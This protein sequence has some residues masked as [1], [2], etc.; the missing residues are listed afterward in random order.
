MNPI[1][2]ANKLKTLRTLKGLSPEQVAQKAELNLDDYMAL[3]A[4]KNA[5][6]EDKLAKA[7]DALGVDIEEWFETDNS[8]VFIN[9]GEVSITENSQQQLNCE[10]CYFYNRN[11]EDIEMMNA[12]TAALK[13]M[14]DKLS[15]EVLSR[16]VEKVLR[17]EIKKKGRGA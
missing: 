3:E 9:S 11:E 12:M 14:A 8:N 16:H 4:G 2:T 1:T 10:N 13:Q 6:A 7:C 15:D 5:V 17:E